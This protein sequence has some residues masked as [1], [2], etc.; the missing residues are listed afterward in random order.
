M[1]SRVA[2]RHVRLPSKCS[3]PRRLKRTRRLTEQYDLVFIH[4]PQPGGLLAFHR[5]DG[6][7]WVWR[8]HIDTS[9][10]NLET[11]KF[12]RPYLVDYDA[13]VFTMAEFVPPDFPVG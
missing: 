8:C 4:D 5:K 12:L 3:T 7:R 11:W 2:S 1:G 13:A 10:P 6:A 9:C